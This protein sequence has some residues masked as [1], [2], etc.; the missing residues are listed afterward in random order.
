MKCPRCGGD[1]TRVTDSRKTEQNIKRIRKCADC[2][3]TFTTYE[4]AF[5]KV[6]WVENHRD[7]LKDEIEDLNN[8][9]R[10]YEEMNYKLWN[11]LEE[12]QMEKSIANK[13]LTDL[14]EKIANKLGIEGGEANDE[15]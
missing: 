14:V 4:Y 8:M 2:D 9:I 3:H 13:R 12:S 1:N 7:N 15:A 5:D 10:E 6:K 11:Q